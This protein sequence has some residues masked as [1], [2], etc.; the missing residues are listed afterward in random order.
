MVTKLIRPLRYLFWSLPGRGLAGIWHWI[1]AQGR[2]L[3]ASPLAFYRM[4]CRR[5]D[6]VFAKIEYAHQESAKWRAVWTGLKAPY[7]LLRYFGVSPQVAVG[8]LVAGSTAGTGV[9][10]NETVFA[11]KSFSRGD[12]GAYIAPMDIPAIVYEEGDNTLLIQLSSVPVAEISLDSI[13]VGT[14]YPNSAL[15]SGETNAIEIG[16][17]AAKNNYLEVGHLIIDRWRCT[18]F[19]ME[20]TET[21][22]LIVRGTRADGLS[23]SPTVGTPIMRG[24]GGGNRAENMAVAN[25]TYDQIR[26]E[27]PTLNVNGQVD[28]LRIE[29]LLT[30]GGG[31]LISRVKADTITVD[32]IVVGAGNGLAVKDMV[33]ATSTVFKVADLDSNTEELISPP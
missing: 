27:T 25:S 8:L 28:V 30:K 23:V 4:V 7:N 5:R 32:R 19:R 33:I 17:S 21:H 6:W 15:P 20:D 3:R 10:V 2:L 22:T 24:I 9:I 11:N 31:C 14:S 18:T 1:C 29:S 13:S 26:I 16:G 12:P